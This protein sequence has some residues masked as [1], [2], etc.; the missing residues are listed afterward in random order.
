MNMDWSVYPKTSN[1]F[2]IHGWYVLAYFPTK[3]TTDKTPVN[4]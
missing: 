3:Q 1:D 2:P 4:V